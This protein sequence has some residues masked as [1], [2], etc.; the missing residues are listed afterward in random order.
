MI[1]SMSA[2]GGYGMTKWFTWRTALTGSVLFAVLVGLLALAV[3]P[4]DAAGSCGGNVAMQNRLPLPGHIIP[5]LHGIAP[6][7]ALE[8]SQS[9]RLT[10]S[11]KPR[12]PA[13]LA[14]FLA[15][16]NDPASPDY[17][18][19]LT[20]QEYAASFGQP[21]AVLDQIV[22]FLHGAGFIVGEI[23]P[24]HLSISAN[25]TVAQIESAFGVQ[26][27][28]FSF[29][30]RTVHAPLGEPSVP[31]TIAPAIQAILGLSDVAQAFRP[32]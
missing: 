25:A 8:C 19:F 18:H 14:Q 24:N 13:A 31:S 11:L 20:P 6:L 7:G 17:H 28:R 26:L 1:A 30:G 15:A 16:L 3:A 32:R 23:A 21:Q 2:N 29:Q 27:M 12:D 10:I 5:V 22:T 9:L 4:A